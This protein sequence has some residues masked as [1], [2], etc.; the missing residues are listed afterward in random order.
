VRFQSSDAVTV[1]TN[2]KRLFRFRQSCFV[3]P[4]KSSRRSNIDAFVISRRG[5]LRGA[6]HGESRIAAPMATAI[7]RL[8]D[9]SPSQVIWC[10]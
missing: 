9:F 8:I 7:K 10:R 4:A 6:R 1:P 3:A 5:P 2:P